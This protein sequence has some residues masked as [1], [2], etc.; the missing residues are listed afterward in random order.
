MDSFFSAAGVND[1]FEKT[2]FA[3]TLM[4]GRA[5][6]WWRS[7]VSGGFNNNHAVEWPMFVNA[8]RVHFKDTDSEYHMR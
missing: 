3:V 1:E 7:L 8:L 4:D 6:A 5:L 2:K